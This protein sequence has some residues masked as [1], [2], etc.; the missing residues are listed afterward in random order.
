MQTPSPFLPR[1][2][3]FGIFLAV[4]GLAALVTFPPAAAAYEGFGATTPGGSGGIVVHVTNLNDSGPGSLREALSQGN[5][6]VVFDVAG[7]IALATPVYVMGAFVTVDGLTAPAPGITLRGQGLYITGNRGAHDIIVRQVR[8]RDSAEDGIQVAWSAHNVVIDHVSVSGSMDGNIDIT[9]GA[10]DV[11]VS[12]SILGPHPSGKN[13]LIGYN[14]SRIT[15][16][17][18]IFANS[19]GRNP[20]I[21]NDYAGTPAPDTTADMRNNIVW[22]WGGGFGTVVWYGAKTNVVNNFYSSNRGDKED[23]LIACTGGTQAECVTGYPASFAWAHVSGNFN[24]DG[25]T[26]A[27]N[28]LGNEENLFPAPLVDTLEACTAAYHVL[29]DAGARPRDAADQGL[30][31][32]ISLPL[33]VGVAPGQLDFTG[34]VGGTNPPSQTLGVSG[35]NGN[36]FVWSAT[37]TSGPWLSVFPANGITPSELE[38]TV[39]LTDLTAGPYNGTLTIEAGGA[40]NSPVVVPFSLVVEA[41]TSS[42]P[43]LVIPA[44]S[45]SAPGSATAGSS[46]SISEITQNQGDGAAGPSTTNFYLSTDTALNAGDLLLGGRPV[47]S[48]P[49]GGSSS[50]TTSVTVPGTVS[51]GAYYIIAKADANDEVNETPEINNTSYIPISILSGLSGDIAVTAINAPASVTQGDP[52]T[53]EVT[54]ENL[55]GSTETFDLVLRDLSAGLTIE[56]NSGLNVSAGTSTK[57]SFIWNTTGAAPGDHILEAE[58]VLGSDGNS[59]NNKKAVTVTVNAPANVNDMYVWSI[60]LS[61]KSRGKGGKMKDLLVAVTVQ[62]DNDNDGADSDDPLKSGAIVVIDVLKGNGLL[63]NDQ[64]AITNS[65]GVAKWEFKN[66]GTGSFTIKV[67]N[68]RDTLNYNPAKNVKT[69]DTIVI[70]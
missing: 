12:W 67:E 48:L 37:V 42:G 53:V 43:D 35:F 16:H 49:Q 55:G 22:D 27:I 68:V 39:D 61:V 7:E 70:M 59:G 63:L 20:Y 54:V 8:V 50:A 52:I 3:A 6:T 26:S 32:L 15:L 57:G 11:T 40:A 46:I 62:E 5:R 13:M 9:H 44:S 66:V 29:A 21:S 47:P 28:A 10:H 41:S 60:N 36:G 65:E 38:V 51:A 25:L 33:C 19:K 14:P 24:A 18:N 1:S 45:L 69:Q 17:H 23:A 2:L 4:S 64:L 34:F 56:T 31:P 58:A 30:L